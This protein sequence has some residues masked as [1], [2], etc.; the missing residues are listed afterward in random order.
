MKRFIFLWAVIFIY[1]CS[2]PKT[3]E[4]AREL[5]AESHTVFTSSY[6][7]FV[8]FDPLIKGQSSRFGTHVTALSN[9]K[10]M[11]TG[12]MTVVLTGQRKT[13]SKPVGVSEN[14]GIYRATLT[15]EETGKF[16][17]MFLF[18]DNAT[19][20]TFL[21]RGVEVFADQE[22]AIAGAKPFSGGS[23]VFLKEQAWKTDFGIEKVKAMQFHGVIRTAGKIIPTTSGSTMVIAKNP[24]IV[25]FTKLINPGILIE[26]GA[27]VAAVTGQGLSEGNP[28]TQL[29]NAKENYEKS[30]KDY[31]RNTILLKSN[32]VSRPDFEASEASYLK[33]KKEYDILTENIKGDGFE[34]YAPV[35]G[36]LTRLLVNNGSKVE[37]GMPIA[38]IISNSPVL[39]ETMVSSKYTGIIQKIS[40]GLIMTASNKAYQ[41]SQ[42]N[43]RMIGGSTNVQTLGQIPVRFEI[44]SN[45]D[46]VP[47][48]IATVYLWYD[49][50]DKTIT[51]PAS[52]IV[53]EQG[54]YYVFIE[55]TGE[56]FEKRRVGI[57]TSDGLRVSITDG[58]ATDEWVAVKG[59]MLVKLASMSGAIPSHGH[60]H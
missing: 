28:E 36:H 25:T 3:E 19:V 8:E 59:A 29:L 56:S 40:D 24:G 54:T 11:T 14:P 53:E 20:D 42:C 18:A 12:Q 5:L 2:A 33:T 7:L 21:I 51:V 55:K 13:E 32:L 52:A 44:V 43:G 41:I 23:I 38:E 35:T 22:K 50:N 57:S 6:E 26:K 34:I 48:S 58:L 9:Y 17:L 15:P 46:L 47:G 37:S 60:V 1:S 27:L 10:P 4:H 39:L 16:D 49:N 30:K 31:D 45:A